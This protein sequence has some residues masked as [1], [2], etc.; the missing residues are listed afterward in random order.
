MKNYQ[1]V[2]NWERVK[3]Q[4]YKMR[5]GQNFRG[6]RVENARPDLKGGK[7]RSKPI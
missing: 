4:E 6:A 7:C 3:M 2:A 5:Y 1:H